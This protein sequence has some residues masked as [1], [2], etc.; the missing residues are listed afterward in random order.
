MT[1][2]MSSY[3][4]VAVRVWTVDPNRPR[5]KKRHLLSPEIRH[6][7]VFDTETTVDPTQRLLFGAFRYCRVD[8]DRDPNGFTVTT[9][10]EGLIY[11]DDL[12]DRDPARYR[13]LVDYAAS[14]KA[15]VDLLY[16][17]VEPSWQLHLVS[18]TEFARGWLF[19]VGYPHNQRRDPATVVAFNMPFD[20]SRISVGVSDARDDM[21]GGFSL[22]V[23][24]DPDGTRDAWKPRIAIKNLDSKR[25]L[26]KFRR[27]ERPKERKEL[28]PWKSHAGHLLDLRT[29]VFALT[30]KSH[31]L[32]TACNAYDVPGKSAP[33][34]FGEV[35]EDAI[36]YCRQD[37]AATTGLYEVAMR[38]FYRHPIRLQPTIAYSPASVGK[39]YLRAMGVAPRLDLDTVDP[40]LL[41][42]VMAAFYGGRAE[43]HIRKTPLPVQ[44]LDFTSMYPTVDVLMGAWDIVTAAKVD[45]VEAT[46]DVQ[47]FLDSVTVDALY[48]RSTWRRMLGFGAIIPD[49]DVVPIRAAYRENDWSIGVNHLH[50]DRPSWYT[51]PDLVASKILTGKTPTAT[52]A[53]RLTP[54]D[55]PQPT[56]RT[57]RLRGQVE[58]DPAREDFFAV[59]VQQRQAAK[60]E[61]EQATDGDAAPHFELA[62]TLKVLVNSTGYGIFAEMIRH[63]QAETSRVAVHGPGPDPYEKP[64][65]APETPGECSYPPLAACIT[66]AARLMLAMLEVAVT[67]QGGS[68]VMCDTDSMAIIATQT[69]GLHPCRGGDHVTSTGEAAVLALSLAQVSDIQTRFN[70]L[71]PYD[72]DLIP[73]VLHNEAEGLIQAISAKRYAIYRPDDDGT[74][75]V[76][77]PSAH[78][79]GHLLDP[80]THNRPRR[81]ADGR[82]IWVDDVW[83]WVIRAHENPETPLPGWA[84]LPAMAR[85]TITSTTTAKPFTRWNQGKRWADQV[86]PFN[87]LITPTIDPAGYPEGV[88]PGRFRLVAPFSNDPS[89]WLARDWYNLYDPAGPTYRI[90]TDSHAPQACGLVTVKTYGDVLRQ[91]QNHP[92][93]KFA[94]AAGTPCGYHTAGVLRR[95]RVDVRRIH[96]IGKEAN[97]IDDVAAGLVAEPGDVLITYHQTDDAYLRRVILPALNHLGGRE[98]AKHCGV[99]RRTIDRVRA[100]GSPSDRL[101]KAL[102]RIVQSATTLK[103]RP[104]PPPPAAT[105]P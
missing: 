5:K 46:G 96:H 53:Y 25:A 19:H 37:V 101:L 66:G 62:A 50:S 12:P 44:Q 70:L 94:D 63:E 35:T 1:P 87:F 98:L 2:H 16:E 39:A 75:Q 47:E 29:L 54:S 73:S 38:D 105:E 64:V 83:E 24:G 49:G 67:S 72:P 69:G 22:T 60:R 99:D 97:R 95:R 61:A 15:H 68:W 3:L 57:V 33:P 9:V 88:D 71:N 8:Q 79:L 89:Q 13:L 90:T 26:K 4:P 17:D 92:E 58:V 28:P 82:L 77:K 65:G 36:D 48:C 18:R 80:I 43:V 78:G 30:G 34:A 81:K 23:F 104:D 52:Q 74:V 7:L 6:V 31:S 86:K 45:I 32:D 91:Y 102:E 20:L 41:G 103:P 14:H 93:H 40:K 11:A 10:A 76:V 59:V 27:L 85:V 100:G 42:Y 56:L 51:I 84:G 55:D 21:Y